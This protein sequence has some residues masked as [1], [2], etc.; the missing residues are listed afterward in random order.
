[1]ITLHGYGRADNE[2][3]LLAL[4]LT[5]PASV[6]GSRRP[7]MSVRCADCGLLGLRSRENMQLY[8]ADGFFRQRGQ[9]LPTDLLGRV[10]FDEI[11]ICAAQQAIFNV[12]D[13]QTFPANLL[14][15]ITS[16]RDC[17]S[18]VQWQRGKSPKEHEAIMERQIEVERDERRHIEMMGVLR[19]QLWIMGFGMM[20]ATIIAAV[21]ASLLSR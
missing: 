5:L 11:P 16:Q 8:E 14:A 17:S 6:G 12:P 3:A 19:L 9:Q 10:R 4:M 21:V 7:D 18:F 15:Q 1:M 20:A 13:M 2:T